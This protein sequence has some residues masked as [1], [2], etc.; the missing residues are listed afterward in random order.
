MAFIDVREHL[1]SGQEPLSA[2]L[3]IVHGL[4]PGEPLEVVAPFEPFPLYS[5]MESRGFYHETDMAPDG[6]W[7]VTF[8]QATDEDE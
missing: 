1:A 6:G 2:I 7:H 8:W 4:E 5:L 3:T